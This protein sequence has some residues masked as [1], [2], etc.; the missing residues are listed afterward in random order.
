MKYITYM[1]IGHIYTYVPIRYILYQVYLKKV[2]INHFIK[3]KALSKLSHF[4]LSD[5]WNMALKFV[6]RLNRE[7]QERRSAEENCLLPSS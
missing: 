3:T 7:D 2:F 5:I 6:L 1:H 4:N